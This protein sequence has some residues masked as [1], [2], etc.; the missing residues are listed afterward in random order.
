MNDV[1]VLVVEDNQFDMTI[2]TEALKAAEIEYIAVHNSVDAIEAAI[3]H[4]PS[5]ALLDLNMPVI[6][7]RE[8]CETLQKEPKTNHI[9]VI[10]LT[11]SDRAEDILFGVRMH[12]AYYVKGVSIQSLIKGI[13]GIDFAVKLEEEVTS[14]QNLNH[15]LHNKYNRV[16]ELH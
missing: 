4:Q 1:S 10:F 7:G 8:L 5:I 2:I 13:K 15:A 16:C 12:A 3:K 11:A 9:K 14:Y 6:D